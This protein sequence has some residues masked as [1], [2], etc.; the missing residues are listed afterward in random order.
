MPATTS[1]LAL[2]YPLPADTVDVPR[3]V[4]ALADRT[5]LVLGNAS[6]R[7]ACNCAA[8]ASTAMPANAA[9]F[10]LLPF[11]A[12]TASPGA[13][14]VFVRNAEGSVTVKTAGWYTIAL[15]CIGDTLPSSSQ[16]NQ[17]RLCINTAADAT[18]TVGMTVCQVSPVWVPE[19]SITWA[20]QLPAN[21]RVCILAVT[22]DTVIRNASVQASGLSGGPL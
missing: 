7:Y 21:S 9:A 14:G 2:P 16:R 10:T 5:D 13:S 4:Q 12:L 18:P 3:D 11:G 8:G 6:K 15:T 1:V 19:A 20:G 22:T 17:Y